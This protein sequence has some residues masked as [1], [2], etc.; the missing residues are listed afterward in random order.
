MANVTGLITVNS[1]QV[2]EVDADP[3]AGAGTPAPIGS[4]AMFDSG[5]VGTLHIKTG[6]ADTAWSLV[7]SNTAD[8]NLTGNNLT[9]G[10]PATPTEYFGSNND[11]DVISKRNGVELTRLVTA[12]LLVGLNASLGG[13][14]QV[15][16]N[17]LGDEVTKLATANGGIGT[18]RV[19]QVVRQYKVLTTD[20]V[21]TA[22]ATIAVPLASRLAVEFYASAYQTSGASGATGDGASY[23]RTTDVKRVAGA[24]SIVTNQSSF[25]SE[26]SGAFNLSAAISGNN[27]VYS[28]I[29]NTNRNMTW[30]GNARIFITQE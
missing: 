17:A 26:D 20:A 8:W 28:A 29:G 18:A 30:M 22:L 24:P 1:K 6:A 9:G 12:G 21:A 5:T 10:T 25:T 13:R 16:A 4:I 2:L 19:I 23:Q 11:Y 15:G 14:L 3:A 7:D 27:L